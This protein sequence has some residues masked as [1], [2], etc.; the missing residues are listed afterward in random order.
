MDQW[1]VWLIVLI[2]LAITAGFVTHFVRPA[3]RIRQEFKEVARKL[4]TLNAAPAGQ[5]DLRA[6]IAAEVMSSSDA[7]ARVWGEYAQTLHVQDS[8]GDG[9]SRW[10][11]T[12]LAETFFTDQSLVDTPLKTEYYKHLPGILTGLGIIGTFSGLIVGLSN[13]TVS[14]DPAQAQTQLRLLINAVGHA[15]IVSA[16]AITLAMLFTWAEKSL[17]TVCYRLTEE[18]RQLID[19]LFDVGVDVE[20]LERLVHAAEK[21]VTEV[22]EI[23]RSLSESIGQVFID[24][25][26]RQIDASEKNSAR[27]AQDLA[28]LLN[29]SLAQPIGHIATAVETIGARQDETVTRLVHEVLVGFS[30]NM[31][32]MFAGRMAELQ[33]VLSGT[34][35]AMQGLVDQF[36]LMAGRM[37]VSGKEAVQKMGDLV[38]STQSESG[39]K[40]EAL[41]ARMANVT[42]ETTG[43]LTTQVERMVAMSI[44]TQQRLRETVEALTAVTA[45]AVQGMNEGAA[46]IETASSHFV[47][48]GEHVAQTMDSTAHAAGSMREAASSL[49]ETA[50]SAEQM[51]G[52]YRQSHEAF[53]QMTADLRTTIDRARREAS[54]SAEITD[55]LAHAA[56][57]LGQMERQADS[58]LE[59]VSGVLEHAHLAFRDSVER[60]LREANRQFQAELSQAVGLL[61]GAIADLGHTVDTLAEQGPAK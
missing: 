41:L 13:F 11:A 40:L 2:L 49:H 21:S 32:D 36:A 44:T 60:T 54:L 26:R 4:R 58:Y 51:L 28:Q 10:R 43:G 29:A 24:Q 35:T 22:V 1:Y 17:L 57:H 50:A 48:A 15:F 14:V 7:V 18:I 9:K 38:A 53:A 20:Y 30:R 47:Q 12:A 42:S 23:R 39:A 31:E 46:R 16:I 6:Q 25:T 59:Q 5:S 56:G 34:N 3:L 37:D 8:K 27:M 33:G 52:D 55:R 45:T 61:S 19:G